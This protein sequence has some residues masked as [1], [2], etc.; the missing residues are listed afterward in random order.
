MIRRRVWGF[1]KT[2]EGKAFLESLASLGILQIISYLFPLITLPYLTRVIGV[3]HFGDLALVTA[4]VMY[5]QTFVDWGYNYVGVRA[6]ARCREDLGQVSRIYSE[7]FWGRATLALVS[8]LILGLLVLLLPRLQEIA[9]P[10]FFRYLVVW[11]YILYADW[12]FQGLEQMR[13]MT[14]LNLLA[15]LF[16]TMMVFVVIREAG[17]YIYYPLLM[18]LGFCISGVI[19]FVFI[20]PRKGIRLQ[21]LSLGEIFIS[22]KGA[23]DTYISQS[24]GPYYENL[25]IPTIDAY[26]GGRAS[27]L[28]DAGNKVVVLAQRLNSSLS[29]AFYPLLARRIEHH[30]MVVLVS[31]LTSGGIMLGL[32]LFAPLIV[33]LLFA[34]EFADAVAVL[35]I[36]GLSLFFTTLTNVYGVN[37]LLQMGQERLLRNITLG[38]VLIGGV[39]LIPVVSSGS[40][41]GAAWLL[42][43]TRTL[44]ALIVSY[45]AYQYKRKNV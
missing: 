29:R 18:S 44:E 15:N 34:P 19:A 36:V 23:F 6:V 41:I 31:L 30:R 32:M 25:L 27:G 40:W 45:T 37:Y 24:V 13:Y 20:I 33:R 21:R 3:E 9:L 28:F 42:L 22:L 14:M 38:V 43:A 17:D 35:R 1:V 2:K 10:L 26:S 5:L 16:C 4:V 12:L 11:G 39:A 8:L 7:V